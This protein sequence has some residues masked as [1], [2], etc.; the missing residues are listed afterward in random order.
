MMQA[1]KGQLAQVNI[2]FSVTALEFAVTAARRRTGDFEEH[3]W[4]TA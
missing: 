3:A 4:L 2:D 1:I